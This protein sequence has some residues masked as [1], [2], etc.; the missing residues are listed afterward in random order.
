MH[1]NA[2]HDAVHSAKVSE[3]VK[4]QKG[5]KPFRISRIYASLRC[6]SSAALYKR[7]TDSNPPTRS[8]DRPMIGIPKIDPHFGSSDIGES[9]TSNFPS[10][11]SSASYPCIPDFGTLD[12]YRIRKRTLF[13]RYLYTGEQLLS[14]LS[15]LTT[16]PE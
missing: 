2:R 4:R 11:P 5:I 1:V 15:A 9:V 10:L 12:N 13:V 6:S 16:C 3:S 14:T 8:I 7:Y